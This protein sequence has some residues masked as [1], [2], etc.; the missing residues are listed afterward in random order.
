MIIFLWS[1]LPNGN[2]TDMINFGDQIV[3]MVCSESLFGNYQIEIFFR[4]PRECAVL[5]IDVQ[6]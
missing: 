1:C 6:A 2:I 5:L 3:S 4:S